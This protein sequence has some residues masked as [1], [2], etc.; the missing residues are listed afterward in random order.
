[1]T[2]VIQYN[3]PVKYTAPVVRPSRNALR[4]VVALASA[5]SSGASAIQPK[6]GCPN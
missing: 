3:V 4:V 2:S 5:T 6:A 1:M